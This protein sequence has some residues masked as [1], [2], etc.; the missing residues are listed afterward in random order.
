MVLAQRKHLNVL[1]HDQLV[2]V[3]MKHS[4]VDQVPNILLVPLC[5]EEHGFCVALWRATEAFALWILA[6]TL[7][8]GAHGALELGQAC[9]GLFGGCFEA[10]AGSETC[11][12]RKKVIS[13]ELV[14]SSWSPSPSYFASTQS[15]LQPR[16]I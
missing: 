5:E 10:L 2:V 8:D 6:D 3:L 4:P 7:E 16:L 13:K 14:F 1:D 15:G 9:G 11:T 12:R